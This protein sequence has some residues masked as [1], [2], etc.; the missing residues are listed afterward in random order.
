MPTEPTL[1]KTKGECVSTCSYATGGTSL[2]MKEGGN[3]GYHRM[4][5]WLFVTYGLYM[6][7]VRERARAW[8]S[9]NENFEEENILK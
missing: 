9:I 1:Y 8:I 4:N 5:M 7:E 2:S 3:E 6:R